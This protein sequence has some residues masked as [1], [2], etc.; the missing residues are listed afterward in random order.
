MFFVSGTKKN[1]KIDMM[2]TQLEKKMKMPNLKWHNM[3][4]NACAMTNVKSKLTQ[5]VTLCPAERVSNG[6]VSL[7]ISHPRGPQD[8]AKA[9]TKVQTMITTN[10]A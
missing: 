9:E 7:G 8:Q 1:T 4:R 3:D 10:I 5:T 2:K 6:N